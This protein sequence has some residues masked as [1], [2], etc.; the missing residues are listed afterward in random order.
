M[1]EVHMKNDFSKP[2]CLHLPIH[3]KALNT[4]TWDISICVACVLS[5]VQSLSHAQLFLYPWTAAHQTSLS[6]TT[7]QILLKLMSIASVMPSNHL[8][9]FSS[10]FQSFPASG[11]FLMSQ[12]FPSGGQSIRVSASTSVLPM[13]IQDW[14]PLGLTGLIF[15]LSKWISRVFNTTVQKHQFFGTRL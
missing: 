10:C 15:Y 4:L 12:L 8:I 3:R 14:F 9:L 11:S 7:S 5:S 13:N 2:R 6:I 1:G